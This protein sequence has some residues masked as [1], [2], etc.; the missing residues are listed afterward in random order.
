[1]NIENLK[2]CIDV[3]LDVLDKVLDF[4]EN[5]ALKKPSRI[6]Y[7]NYMIGYMIFNGSDLP[8]DK[9]Q[10][11]IDWYNSVDFNNKSNSKR[12][13]IYANLIDNK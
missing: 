4:I 5:N 12:R 6:D 8:Q 2:K 10:Y 11:L 7:I 9:T 1:M 3:T 13:E